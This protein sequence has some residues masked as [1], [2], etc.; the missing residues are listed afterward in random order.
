M[1]VRGNFYTSPQGA[2]CASML[3]RIDGTS[4]MAVLQ[5]QSSTRLLHA[6]QPV[7]NFQYAVPDNS[8]IYCE[9][10]VDDGWYPFTAS[11][12]EGTAW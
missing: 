2:H 12:G 10:L 6:S 9:V 1:A 3:I 4:L 8:L 11:R 7:R 5:F